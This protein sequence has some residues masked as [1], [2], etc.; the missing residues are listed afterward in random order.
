[1]THIR[2]PHSHTFKEIGAH[3]SFARNKRHSARKVTTRSRRRLDTT[4][5]LSTGL[6]IARA[7]AIPIAI[8]DIA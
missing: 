7:R 3:G 6:R 2:R 4:P 5:Y 8:P 1:M